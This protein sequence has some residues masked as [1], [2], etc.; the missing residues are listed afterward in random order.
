VRRELV[1]AL[2][3]DVLELQQILG[4]DLSG[5]LVER[6]GLVVETR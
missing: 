1:A 2:T 4:R 5:W 6:S 3:D